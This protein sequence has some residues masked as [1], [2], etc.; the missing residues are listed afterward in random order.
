MQYSININIKDQTL[1]LTS[2]TTFGNYIPALR[3]REI[4]SE[5]NISNDLLLIESLY[6]ESALTRLERFKKSSKENYKFIQFALRLI[7]NTMSTVEPTKKQITLN[8]W[9]KMGIKNFIVFSGFWLPILKEYEQMIGINVIVFHVDKGLSPSYDFFWPLDSNYVSKW[10]HDK[11]N[12]KFFL[13]RHPEVMKY[14]NRNKEIV[15]HGGGWGVGNWGTLLNDLSQSNFKII[16]AEIES[17]IN[18]GNQANVKIRPDWIGSGVIKELIYPPM[19]SEGATEEEPLFNWIKKSCGVISKPGGS[20][21]LDCML[22]ATPLVV[23]EP[24]GKHEVEN[25]DYFLNMGFGIEYSAWKR[26]DFSISTLKQLHKNI[27]LYRNQLLKE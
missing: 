10:L 13:R 4:L 25:A 18:N 11:E 15:V 21:L 7:R 24:V 19:V 5:K 14:E 8:S 20:T 3:L 6:S 9:F 27:S 26:N 17:N 23:L 1:I 12:I 16:I 22:T 2:I